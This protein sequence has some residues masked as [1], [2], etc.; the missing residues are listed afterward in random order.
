MEKLAKRELKQENPAS[1]LI[2]LLVGVYFFFGLYA[3]N[4]LAQVFDGGV[5]LVVVSVRLYDQTDGLS[6]WK[7]LWPCAAITERKS[8]W[9]HT[10]T[11]FGA[12]VMR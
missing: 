4:L 2:R 6:K 12:C 10:A 7:I 3:V 11:V 8:V 1:Y 9:I 5:R